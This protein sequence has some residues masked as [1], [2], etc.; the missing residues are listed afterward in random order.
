MEEE[1]REKE[2]GGGEAG[3]EGLEERPVFKKER[4]NKNK[5]VRDAAA[6]ER[7]TP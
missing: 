2:E 5:Q 6:V 4:K 3:R 1:E 7:L